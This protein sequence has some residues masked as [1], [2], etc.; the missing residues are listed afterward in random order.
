MSSS[1]ESQSSKSLL[2]KEERLKS[3]PSPD[4]FFYS[5]PRF[6]FHVDSAFTDKLTKL[7]RE[8]I[9]P[10]SNVLDMMSSW[11]SH[12]PYDIAY[13]DVVGQG[14]NRSELERN[15]QLKSFR[16]HDLNADPFLPFDSEQFDAVLCAVSVQYLQQPELVFKDIH[17]VLKPGGIAIISFSNRM[18]GSKAINAWTSRSEDERVDLVKNYFKSV[19]ESKRVDFENIEAIIDRSPLPPVMANL[20]SILFG[21]NVGG[22]PFYAVCATKDTKL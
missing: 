13:N 2:E 11:V 14:L 15:K 20:I 6:V 12:L 17:R 16:M 19:N 9:R 21:F 7:Y 4:S 10:N 22:D 8:K 1:F 3:D 5:S 18:F